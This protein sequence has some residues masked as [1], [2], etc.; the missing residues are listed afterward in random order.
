MEVSLVAKTS[1]DWQ[2][3]AEISPCPLGQGLSQFL[4]A[5]DD[6]SREQPIAPIK[7]LRR[8]QFAEHISFSFLV[9]NHAFI[10]LWNRCVAG[11]NGSIFTASLTEWQQRV[12]L[13]LDRYEDSL[14]VREV[15]CKIMLLLEAEGF[16]EI[17]SGYTKTGLPNGLFILER[18]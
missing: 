11:K 17:W 9:G 4:V 15:G 18:K 14:A 1:V 6:F 16:A 8:A 3:L 5:L 7:S 10:H 12:I 13:A 2:R